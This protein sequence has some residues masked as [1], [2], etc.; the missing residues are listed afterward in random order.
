VIATISPLLGVWADVGA[1]PLHGEHDALLTAQD[2]DS[3]QHGV[4]ADA[5]LLLE[6]L[7]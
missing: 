4:A 5:V 6:M 7:H 3:P 1:A 2:V